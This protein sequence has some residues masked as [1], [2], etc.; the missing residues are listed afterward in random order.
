[1]TKIENL[2]LRNWGYFKKGVAAPCK[3]PH[4]LRADGYLEYR[5]E[6]GGKR[7][8]IAPWPRMQAGV[9]YAHS[10]FSNRHLAPKNLGTQKGKNTQ[11]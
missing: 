9:A 1:M 5:E 4:P 10:R 7:V 3:V 6:A 2:S 8:K 11:E